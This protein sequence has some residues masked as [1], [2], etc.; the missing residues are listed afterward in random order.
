MTVSQKAWEGTM[1]RLSCFTRAVS[2]SA[3]A[4]VCAF[5]LP[6]TS[7]A[8]TNVDPDAQSVLAGVSNHLG[9]LGRFSVE[10]SAV[11][12][13]VTPEGQKLQFLHSGEIVVQRP[14]RLYATRRGAAGTA[15][16]FLDGTGLTLFAAKANAYLHLAASGID[17]AIGTVHNLGFDA[18]G[19]DLLASKPLDSSTSDIASGAHIGM[20]SIDGVEVHQLAFRGA[21]VDWQLW[22]TAGDK[23][24]PVRYVITTKAIAGAPQY[25][26]QLR[27]WNAAPQIDAARFTFAPP[28]GARRLEPASVT[29][30]AI[31]D[32]TVKGE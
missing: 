3:V 29:V 14:D 4:G 25:T 26:L 19:A 28:Q 13:V 11:D 10:Y 21:E 32:M 12:E 6:P 20:T 18:P 8:Q 9:G 7:G 24:L 22:V 23:P 27:N 30:N 17:A 5:A 16:V 15:E 1:K 2:V 31:G